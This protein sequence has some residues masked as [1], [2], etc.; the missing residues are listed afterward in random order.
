[1]NELKEKP[2]PTRSDYHRSYYENNRDQRSAERL[3]HKYVFERCL[4]YWRQ[5]MVFGKERKF[6]LAGATENQVQKAKESYA[7]TYFETF[8]AEWVEG[9]C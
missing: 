8:G 9:N 3:E 4:S 7:K 2:D 6:L 1:M 5:K